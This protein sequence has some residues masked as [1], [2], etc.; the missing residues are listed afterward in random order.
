[1]ENSDLRKIAGTYGLDT[2]RF[3]SDCYIVANAA[4]MEQTLS[5]KVPAEM[6]KRL[7]YVHFFN[8]FSQ[9]QAGT[10][11]RLSFCKESREVGIIPT[12][13]YYINSGRN[14]GSNYAVSF[15]GVSAFANS[16]DDSD[17]SIWVDFLRGGNRGGTLICP[18][19]L[20]VIC[21][22]IKF[23]VKDPANAARDSVQK[24]AAFIGCLSMRK[25]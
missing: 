5:I 15:S 17:N 13:N 16:T 3:D 18:I 22:E 7:V 14:T 1:M 6:V 2:F 23:Y 24:C 21:D 8:A 9:V 25:P 19:I 4:A 11:S 12:P 10:V 20:D